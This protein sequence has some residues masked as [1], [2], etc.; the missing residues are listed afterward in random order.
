MRIVEI[1]SAVAAGPDLLM[2]D[3]ASA[4]LGPEESHALADQFLALRDEL[5]LTL[6]VIE[7]HVPLIARVCDYVYCLES[8]ALIAEGVPADVTAQP[9]VIQSFLG[10]AAAATGGSAP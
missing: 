10:R 6:V 1:A 2:L 7:H 5:G 8:G 4:G 9:A 3:E